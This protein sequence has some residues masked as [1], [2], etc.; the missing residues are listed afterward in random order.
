[1]PI[2]HPI[3]FFMSQFTINYNKGGIIMILVSARFKGLK[4]IYSKSGK[5]EI[6]IDFTKCKHKTIYIVG[7]YGS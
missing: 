1:M 5:T 4:G 2:W 6:Y 7:K 3:L